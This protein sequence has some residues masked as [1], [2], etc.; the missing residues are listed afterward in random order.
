MKKIKILLGVYAFL[1]FSCLIVNFYLV[2]EIGSINNKIKYE[3]TVI[4]PSERASNHVFL[5]KASE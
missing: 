4:E 1:V 5:T 3:K 2:N